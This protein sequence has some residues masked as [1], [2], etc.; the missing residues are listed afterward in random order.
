MLLV[1]ILGKQDF[2]SFSKVNTQTYTNNCDVY[3]AKWKIFKNE[4][5]FTIKLIVFYEIW[6]ELLLEP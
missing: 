5:I 1:S 6:L 2:T 4:L 3:Y